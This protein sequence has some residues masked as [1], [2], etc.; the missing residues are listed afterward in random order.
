MSFERK[1]RRGEKK[2]ERMEEEAERDTE[3][4]KGGH[5][6]PHVKLFK[7]FYPFCHLRTLAVDFSFFTLVVSLAWR[8]PGAVHE[9]QSVVWIHLV[10]LG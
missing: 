2:K 1:P 6:V 3:R 10:S 5:L 8:P 4:G 9:R 7:P